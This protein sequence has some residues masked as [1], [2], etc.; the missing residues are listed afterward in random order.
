[1]P[2]SSMITNRMLGPGAAEPPPLRPP[3]EPRASTA[4][5]ASTRHHATFRIVRPPRNE[6]PGIYTQTTGRL[7]PGFGEAVSP[8][9]DIDGRGRARLL[10]QLELL[11]LP[12]GGLGQ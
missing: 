6:E 10:A 12:R 1:M 9:S 8:A 11:D 5:A 2:T 7:F 4:T 3:Q